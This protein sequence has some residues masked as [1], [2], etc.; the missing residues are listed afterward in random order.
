MSGIEV[1]GVIASTAQLVAYA[2]TVSSKLNEIRSKIRNAPK[3]IEQYQHQFEEVIAVAEYMQ[4]NPPIQTEELKRYISAIVEKTT[5]IGLILKKFEESSRNRRR[6]NILSGE[7]SRQLDESFGEIKNTMGNLLL[8]ITSQ[9][10][11]DQRELKDLVLRAPGITTL[12]EQAMPERA[13][14]ASVTLL[15]PGPSIPPLS[16]QAGDF[17][18][19]KSANKNIGSHSFK[20]LQIRGSGTVTMGNISTPNSTGTP[21]AGHSFT[22]FTVSGNKVLHIGNTGGNSEGHIFDVGVMEE[23]EVVML[24]DYSDPNQKLRDSLLQHGSR[25]RNAHGN[26]CGDI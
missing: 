7:L 17:A 4:K 22:D 13:P 19:P 26:T 25:L 24:G 8:L 6:W 3:K 21:M 16:S 15:S 14:A 9:N 2:I 20:G 18:P 12:L 1:L 23:N 5:A 11:R 10:A